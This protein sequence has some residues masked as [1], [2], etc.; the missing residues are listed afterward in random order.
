[1]ADVEIAEVTNNGRNEKSTDQRTG[2]KGSCS[3]F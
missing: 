3:Q 1:M 2:S